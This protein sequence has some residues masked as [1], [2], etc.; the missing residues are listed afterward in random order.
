MMTNAMRGWLRRVAM[1]TTFPM[2][3]APQAGVANPCKPAGL[4][5][6]VG[7]WGGRLIVSGAGGAVSEGLVATPLAMAQ[8]PWDRYRSAH[9]SR[10]W[11][12]GQEVSGT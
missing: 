8:E 11:P 12:L 9:R 1:G 4:H 2:L 3:T 7:A 6:Y 10:T 5:H